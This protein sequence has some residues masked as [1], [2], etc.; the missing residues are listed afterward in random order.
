MT[1]RAERAPKDSGARFFSGWRP[2]GWGG[3]P[4]RRFVVQMN[5]EEL[6]GSL[7]QDFGKYSFI[8]AYNTVA[9]LLK[10]QKRQLFE[11]RLL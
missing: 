5:N 4:G 7:L 11:K 6:T 3:P 8:R 9:F 2:G 10:L 1:L